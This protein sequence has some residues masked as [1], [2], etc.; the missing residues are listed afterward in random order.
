MQL[1]DLP[2]FDIQFLPKALLLIQK[3]LYLL[4]QLGHLRLIFI[5]LIEILKHVAV[6][7]G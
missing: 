4:L 3:P 5:F 1:F 2:I 7:Q 6:G